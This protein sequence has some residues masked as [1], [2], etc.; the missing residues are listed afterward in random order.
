MDF[1]PPHDYKCENE[2][3]NEDG[4]DLR[5]VEDDDEGGPRVNEIPMLQSP[6]TPS[7]DSSVSNLQ[8]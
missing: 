3:R 7:N 4:E 8:N 5:D 6:I 2:G 1:L